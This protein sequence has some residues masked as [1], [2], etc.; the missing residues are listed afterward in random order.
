MEKREMGPCGQGFYTSN[1][2]G[3]EPV[4]IPIKDAEGNTI[5]DKL[6]D[7]TPVEKMPNTKTE[8]KKQSRH[9]PSKEKNRRIKN[10]DFSYH[11]GSSD[12]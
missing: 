11:N 1:A 6:Q 4:P 3:K 2:G 5:E 9:Y 8:V 12:N 10:G 7:N